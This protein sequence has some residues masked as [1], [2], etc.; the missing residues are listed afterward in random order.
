MPYSK[1]LP[2]GDGTA[3]S[4]Q[5]LPARGIEPGQFAR[6]PVIFMPVETAQQAVDRG[7]CHRFTRWLRQVE[8]YPLPLEQ[9]RVTAQTVT[10]DQGFAAFQVELPIVPVAGQHASVGQITFR[11]GITFM[12]TAVVAGM[13]SITGTEQDN[14]ASANSDHLASG[15]FQVGEAGDETVV[16]G[17]HRTFPKFLLS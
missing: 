15:R 11:Q 16:L 6:H 13:D 3:Y 9:H 1:Q 12:R 5:H 7:F 10:A 14:L 8:Q 17:W 4:F 2:V